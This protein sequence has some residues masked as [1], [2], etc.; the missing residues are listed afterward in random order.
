MPQVSYHVIQDLTTYQSFLPGIAAMFSRIFRRPFPA[1][2][3]SQWYLNNPYGD[4][5]VILAREGD[6]LIGHHA[7][8]P[9][10][11]ENAQGGRIPYMLSISTMVDERYRDVN[12]FRRLISDLHSAAEDRGISLILGFPNAKSL[13][14][15]KLLFRYRLLAESTLCSWRPNHCGERISVY[16]CESPCS[17]GNDFSYPSD[18]RYWFW[19]ATRCR[20]KCVRVND[21]MEIIYKVAKGNVLTVLDVKGEKGDAGPEDLAGLAHLAGASS[22]RIMSRHAA[23][24]R[25]PEDELVPHEDYVVRMTSHVLSGFLP[26]IRFSLLLSDVF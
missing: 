26:T 19:R 21:C 20:L 23:I 7:L 8:I 25:I 3:W 6:E 10:V 13:V 17:T 22:V 5:L 14:P 16:E 2:G 4:P 9:Q 24:I 15:F 1:D 18:S 12:V 11:L